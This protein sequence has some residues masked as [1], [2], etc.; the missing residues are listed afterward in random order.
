MEGLLPP[1]PSAWVRRASPAPSGL[2]MSVR[3]AGETLVSTLMGARTR[4]CLGIRTIRTEQKVE[5]HG[6]SRTCPSQKASK[7]EDLGHDALRGGHQQGVE[8]QGSPGRARKESWRATSAGQNWP[9]QHRWDSGR[10]RHQSASCVGCRG[11]P[12][13]TLTLARLQAASTPP[14]LLFP[15]LL[16]PFWKQPSRHGHGCLPGIGPVFQRQRAPHWLQP[17]CPRR[18]ICGQLDWR[19]KEDWQD[20]R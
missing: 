18:G 3:K 9:H 13:I 6:P 5:F 1:Q 8:G 10:T 4:F 19:H 20:H 12:G 14:C 16:F 7:A 11:P 15:I 17:R 2:F